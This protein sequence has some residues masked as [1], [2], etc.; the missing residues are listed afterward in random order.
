[1]GLLDPIRSFFGGDAEPAE[2]PVAGEDLRGEFRERAAELAEA[3]PDADLDFSAASLSRL[4]ALAD[5]AWDKERFV[6]AEWA[7]K[8]DRSR[9]FSAVVLRLGAYFGEVLVRE[10]DAAW[11]DDEDLGAAVR[12][13]GE[14]ED[15]VVNVFH[16]A[17]GALREP[18][19]FAVTFETVRTDV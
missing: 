6:D 3:H 5:E 2:E 15:A 18:A 4:D 8:D 7:G 16:V 13:F 14:E 17:A 9:E 11:V 12:V 1:M 19:R 10:E